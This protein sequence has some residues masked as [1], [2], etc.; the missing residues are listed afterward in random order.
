M[1]PYMVL[2]CSS[3]SRTVCGDVSLRVN[4]S[5]AGAPIDT[6]CRRYSMGLAT[7]ASAEA[8]SSRQPVNF[9]ILAA[10]AGVTPLPGSI[11]RRPA[12]CSCNFFNIGIP[13]SAVAACPEVRMRL[14]PRSI[15][16]SSAPRGSRH[17][18]NARWNVMFIPAGGRC[19]LRCRRRE[20]KPRL[21]FRRIRMPLPH[22]CL[23]SC[24]RYP[25]PSR[26]NRL[27][28]AG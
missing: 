23:Q 4:S 16:C 21:R 6:P 18:S 8:C 26:R 2:I 5:A 15:I 7:S 3:S 11:P 9:S 25:K 1:A 28:S 13:C 27:L 22:G 10:L 17:R 24:I 12:A 19:R 14:H 20:S